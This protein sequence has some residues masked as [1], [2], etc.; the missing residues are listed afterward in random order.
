VYHD[1]KAA[2]LDEAHRLLSEADAVV[3]WHGARFD[4][5]HLN[6]EF[7]QA[8]YDPPPPL[9]QIDLYKVVRK[10]FR[11][12]S[13]KLDYI[14]KE[15]G[16]EGKAETGGFQLWLDCMREDRKAWSKMRKYNIQDVIMLEDMYNR[17]LPWITNHPNQNLHGEDGG[18]P[19]CGSGRLQRRGLARTK[20]AVYQRYQ[21]LA[22]GAWSRAVK[23]SDHTE[24]TL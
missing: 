22:C 23:R 21:C 18:C 13:Y 16:I 14:S 3:H 1:G 19:T 15:L 17:L 24:V 9:A 11:F 10:H 4:I 7:L 5:P 20:T 12:P 8:G 2:M 6:R